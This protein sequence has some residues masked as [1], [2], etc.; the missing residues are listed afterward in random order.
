M[1]KEN[2]QKA[3]ITKGI[4]RTVA[5]ILSDKESHWNVSSKGEG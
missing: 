2:E 1:R 5:F 3:Q 4:L